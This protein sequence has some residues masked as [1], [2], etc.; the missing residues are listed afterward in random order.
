MRKLQILSID[1]KSHSTSE[2]QAFALNPD[3]YDELSSYIQYVLGVHG[4]VYLST[5]NRIEIYYDAEE[6]L[7]ELIIEKWKY[8]AQINDE[9]LQNPITTYLG[10]ESCINHILQLC[11]GTKSAI[12]GDD[13]ILSQ[14]K[15]AF[16]LARTNGTMSTLLERAY[17]TVMKFHKQVCR[18]TEYR[19]IT[20]S[21]AYHSLKSIY[22]YIPKNELIMKSVLII[23]AG[24]MAAQVVKY[25]PKFQFSSVSI[26]NRTEEK[27][28]KLVKEKNIEVVNYANIDSS[29]YDIVISCTDQGYGLVRNI[30]QLG[31]YIDL[32]LASANIENLS[33]P[34]I[35]L[36]ELQSYIT[37]QS[38]ARL[39]SLNEVS[40]IMI[41]HE[42]EYLTWL[43]HWWSRR[44]DSC[45]GVA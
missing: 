38:T 15:K 26:T 13:Q 3:Q 37:A 9:N 36:E 40:L 23:G 8:L 34:G 28:Q 16:E 24:A 4:H 25:L 29:E 19:N 5:C 12:V 43:G 20:V 10:S 2:R 35:L 21:L 27:A 14:L 18:D 7:R 33:C 32:S 30:T 11:I 39:D 6:D 44:K 22:Q 17:Q 42:E 31:F 45:T 41:K 1:H